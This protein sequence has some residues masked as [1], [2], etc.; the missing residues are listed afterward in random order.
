MPY[1]PRWRAH[2]KL[3]HEFIDVST[4]KNY[5]VNQVKA[6]SNF[7]INLYQTPGAFRKHINLCVPHFRDADSFDLRSNIGSP[8]R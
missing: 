7:L 1:G 8:A 4:V 2:R 6:V 3:F 5:D